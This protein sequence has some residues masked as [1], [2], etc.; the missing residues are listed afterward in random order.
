KD[1]CKIYDVKVG[2]EKCNATGEETICNAKATFYLSKKNQSKVF[3]TIEMEETY[4]SLSGKNRKKGNLTELYGDRNS[5]VYFSDY[6]FDGIEDLVISNGNYLPY[7]GISNDVFLYS[8]TKRKYVRNDDL[9]A[10]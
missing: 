1:K 3:Q 10:L 4:L 8:K 9:S 6:N 7:G 5:G 2:F